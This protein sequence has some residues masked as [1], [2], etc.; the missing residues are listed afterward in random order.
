MVG[1]CNWEISEECCDD[2]TDL[3]GPLQEQA[4]AYATLVLWSATGRQFGTCEVTVR[5]CG[6]Y[7]QQGEGC[8][9]YYWD[10]GTWLPYIFNGIW[11]NC[12]CGT[13][14][15][16]QS[17]EP[18]C[19]VY[20]PGP[21]ASIEE[22]LLDGAIV[23]PATYRVDDFVWLVRTGGDDNCWPFTQN[24]DADPPDTDTFQVTYER[25]TA[26]PTALLGAAGTL[27]CE[28]A[29]ACQGQPCRLP[30]RVSSVARQGVSVTMVDV[31]TLLKFGLTGIKEVDDVIR[32]LNPHGLKGITR[33]Y[34]PDLPSPRVTTW[35]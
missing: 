22:V 33:F 30:G 10:S 28:Y 34:S 35:P 26:V 1:P 6:R 32:A 24:F 5:P 13:G 4:T 16:C 25:G 9:G 21:V 20:L 7:C 12:W 15:G 3:P 27:A 19:Q 2:W 8:A 29:R 23:D 31:D 14:P 17:C 18:R 11:R